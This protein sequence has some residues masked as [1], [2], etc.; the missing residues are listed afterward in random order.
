MFVR[1]L[2]RHSLS[3]EPA[4]FVIDERQKLLRRCGIALLNRVENSRDVA[5]F[6]QYKAFADGEWDRIRNQP[7]SFSEKGRNSTSLRNDQSC[8]GSTWS[9]SVP[10]SAFPPARA[11]D[12]LGRDFGPLLH[13]ATISARVGATRRRSIFATARRSARRN[14][15]P[16]ADE[17]D[18]ANSRVHHERSLALGGISEC[19]KICLRVRFVLRV[20]RP[21]WTVPR[22]SVEILADAPSRR[23]DVQVITRRVGDRTA[24]D[25][26]RWGCRA[27][28]EMRG[29]GAS[30]CIIQ[31]GRQ[32][33]VA[34]ASGRFA[35]ATLHLPGPAS[36]GDG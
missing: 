24:V 25:G 28:S 14:K 3:G 34:W 21:R 22:S 35:L 29:S 11:T 16:L 12:A 4:E 32:S 20:I 15:R 1:A 36:G 9:R 27:G 2:F 23:R 6:H 5:H 19:G 13:Q 26:R 7:Q 18:L 8:K 33:A 31:T 10:R 30:D 17:Y